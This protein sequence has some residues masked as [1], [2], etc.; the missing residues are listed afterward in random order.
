MSM[1][2]KGLEMKYYF[3]LIFFALALFYG[4]F[5]IG[6]TQGPV[7][8]EPVVQADPSPVPVGVKS[9]PGFKDDWSVVTISTVKSKIASLNKAS[10]MSKFCPLY[11]SMNIDE[12][13]LAWG[14]LLSGIVKFESGYNP[15]STMTESDGSVSQGLFQLTY[16]NAHCPKSRKE[17]DLNDPSVN[18]KCAVA[19]MADEVESDHVVAAGGYIKYGAPPAKGIA[20]YWSVMRVPDSKSKHHLADIAAMAAKAPGCK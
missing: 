11:S 9:I 14:Y 3:C 13:A 7:I 18:I 8:K 4:L 12:Q 15:N 19:I 2:N 1:A 6:C 20:K 16:G 5:F 10:D 17:A